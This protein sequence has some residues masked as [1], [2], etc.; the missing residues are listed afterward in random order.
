MLIESIMYFALGFLAAGLLAL[1]IMPAVWKRAVRLTRMRIE[2]A[3]PITM[4]EFR[5]DKD[6]LRAEF[7]LST[8]RLERNVEGLR[9]RLAEQV[10]D[11]SRRK[12]ELVQAK[13]ERD[14]KLT[15]IGEL[16]DR[17]NELRSRVLELEKHAADLAQRLRMRDRDYASLSGQLDS[18][19][20]V[21]SGLTNMPDIDQL[22]TDLTAERERAS[23]FESQ[24]RH[25]L[26]RLET[27]E[28]DSSAAAR[29]VAEL[30]E[31]LNQRNDESDES[32]L[33][34]SEA[35]AR[36]ASAENR[37]NALLRETEQTLVDEDERHA[38]LLAEKL[39]LE[40][41][42]ENLRNKVREVEVSVLNDWEKERVDQSHLRE[43]LNDIASEVS[44]LV[45]AVDGSPAPSEDESLF[46]K[47]RK[48]AGDDFEAPRP[49]EP[50]RHDA[51][52][53]GSLSDRMAAL[54]EIQARQ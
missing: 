47:V 42:M 41:E 45:Y 16:E 23:F 28:H 48:F 49:T 20:G 10:L 19:R 25:L 5:A 21:E 14:E 52:R 6:Q 22:Y 36:I 39:S 18:M 4:A 3:T 34:L 9:A 15:I 11:I 33:A 7:A 12:T 2:A 53:R 32:A 24:A 8:R 44:R 38:E 46:D 31:A 26:A 27:A 43:Q 1:M 37:L 54:R 35:E 40:E 17:E 51:V 13:S 29:A 50:V 30:R